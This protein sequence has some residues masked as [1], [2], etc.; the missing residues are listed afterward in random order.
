[1]VNRRYDPARR[2]HL[3]LAASCAIRTMAEARLGANC[4]CFHDGR[5]S[6][7]WRDGPECLSEVHDSMRNTS[8]FGA[9]K[10]I[11]SQLMMCEGV[12]AI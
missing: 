3:L 4:H 9:Q 2:P 5:W 10:D 6:A 1:M 7:L 8:W 12:E 11:R